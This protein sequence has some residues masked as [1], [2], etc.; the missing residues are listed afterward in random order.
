[1]GTG[2]T[3]TAS[4]AGVYDVEFIKLTPDVGANCNLTTQQ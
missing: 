2:A 4:Q 1:M 3:Y